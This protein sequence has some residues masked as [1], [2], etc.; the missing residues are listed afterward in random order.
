MPIQTLSTYRKKQVPS[1]C[2]NGKY[3]E[4]LKVLLLSFLVPY[5]ILID[6]QNQAL[7][8]MLLRWQVNGE[9]YEL[10]IPK[11]GM[12]QEKIII[13]GANRFEEVEFT[14]VERPRNNK[15]ILN[16]ENSILIKPTNEKLSNKI[17]LTAGKWISKIKFVIKHTR[18]G[19]KWHEYTP[20][21]F[22][23]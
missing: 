9:K 14:A 20:V 3:F 6:V 19:C 4:Y 13:T 8:D 2:R 21:N 15:A 11:Q 12:R 22:I 17:I 7:N 5:H 1:I 23:S 16:G 18:L 10:Q